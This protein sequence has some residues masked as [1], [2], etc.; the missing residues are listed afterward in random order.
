MSLCQ[1]NTGTDDELCPVLYTLKCYNKAQLDL[2]AAEK[3]EMR[4]IVLQEI[5]NAAARENA[6]DI[7]IDADAAAGNKKNKRKNPDPAPSA[8][9][10]PDATQTTGKKKKARATAA[11]ASSHPVVQ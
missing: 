5:N 3:A 9:G 10:E 2:A 4:R 1:H 6:I 8:P 11:A 7:D